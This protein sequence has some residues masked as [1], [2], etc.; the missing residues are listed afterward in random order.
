MSVPASR[1]WAHLTGLL[2]AL[3]AL[4]AQ[5]ERDCSSQV[6]S[7]GQAFLSPLPMHG[8]A[9]FRAC[10]GAEELIRALCWKTCACLGRETMVRI[11]I[12]VWLGPVNLSMS[13]GCKSS[14]QDGLISASDRTIGHNLGMAPLVELHIGCS[15]VTVQSCPEKLRTHYID[16]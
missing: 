8:V 4:A 2:V 11:Q 12:A 1:H 14:C 5:L 3:E 9:F 7:S 16:S 6:H 15:V 13:P 10:A